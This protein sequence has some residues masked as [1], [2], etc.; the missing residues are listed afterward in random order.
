MFSEPADPGFE[1]LSW[2]LYI[3]VLSKC[4]PCVVISTVV[5]TLDCGPGGPWF[6]SEWV[7]ILCEA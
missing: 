2:P 7:Q 3:H 4:N 6:K 1:S 5:T